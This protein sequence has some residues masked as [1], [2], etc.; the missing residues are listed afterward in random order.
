MVSNKSDDSACAA[1]QTPKPGAK[2]GIV[3]VTGSTFGG[4]QTFSSSPFNFPVSNSLNSN[5]SSISSIK[6]GAGSSDVKTKGESTSPY[7]FG[8]STANQSS[9]NDSKQEEG[10]AKLSTTFK[11]GSSSSQ[12]SDSGVEVPKT[13]AVPIRFGS[14]PD[15]QNDKGESNKAT[16]NGS[17]NKDNPSSGGFTF[18]ANQASSESTNKGK[19]NSIAEAAANGLLK[20]PEIKEPVNL[21]E[22]SKQPGAGMSIADAAKTGLLKV[23]TAGEK[24]VDF[25]AAPNVNLFALPQTTPDSSSSKPDTS[26][27]SF[28]AGLA[29]GSSG[30][31]FTAPSGAPSPFSVGAATPSSSATTSAGDSGSSATGSKP[32]T[33]P[34]APAES[35][36]TTFQFGTASTSATTI[37]SQTVSTTSLAPSPF[38]FKAV[39]TTE[40][41]KTTSASP[42]TFMTNAAG[43]STTQAGSFSFGSNSAGTA[44][45]ANTGIF[46]FAAPSTETAASLKPQPQA[47]TGAAGLF[48]F[49]ATNSAAVTNATTQLSSQ[50]FGITSTPVSS[51][52]VAVKPFAFNAGSTAQGF[53]FAPAQSSATA[54]GLQSTF[55]FGGAAPKP[56]ASFAGFAPVQPSSS[57][58]TPF[59]FGASS[60]NPTPT[61]EETME[62]DGNNSSSNPFAAPGKSDSSSIK[63]HFT[64]Y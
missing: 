24:K 40:P 27:N 32:F 42:F 50:T 1:C 59:M 10:A 63:Q 3:K 46:Q 36:L 43:P 35:S 18:G 51:S 13:N 34:P 8:S 16:L 41:A 56:E 9:K 48:Q 5:F 33:N 61:P 31:S 49:G 12:L 47:P 39:N 17:V 60:S 45:S 30:F 2:S 23:P 53:S 57:Q 25:A 4:S 64:E 62:A 28:L 15:N 20:V 7:I 38:G 26:S 29:A 52:S 58:Q 44:V 55:T 6:F 11:F 21:E 22:T 37:S 54:G 14:F 19:L